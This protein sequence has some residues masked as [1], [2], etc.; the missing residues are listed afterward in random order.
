MRTRKTQYAWMALGGLICLF[1]LVLACK[2]RDGNKA[3]AQPEPLPT[4]AESGAKPVSPP[5]LPP[6]LHMNE[7]EKTTR[8]SRP[9][10]KPSS[11]IRVTRAPFWRWGNCS[12]NRDALRKPC[13]STG[14]CCGCGQTTGM[15]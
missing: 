7:P 14:R 10:G 8:R 1:G 5:A 2:L 13:L 3:S 15:R 4:L 12:R 6:L 11:L 9:C